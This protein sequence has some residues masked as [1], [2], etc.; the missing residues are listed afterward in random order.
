MT[1]QAKTPATIVDDA[2]VG[3][4]AWTNPANAG[5]SDDVYATAATTTGLTTHYLNAQNCGF[6]IPADARI[7]GIAVAVERKSSGVNHIDFRARI[8]KGGAISAAYTL[9]QAQ[10]WPSTDGVAIYGGP[11][12]LWAL[13]WTPADING[14]GFG[15]ALAVRQSGGAGQTASVDA[16]TITVYYT[17]PGDTQVTVVK[18]REPRPPH[19]ALLTLLVPAVRYG[20]KLRRQQTA[21]FL[22]SRSDPNLTD[23]RD[24][25]L[26]EEPAMVTIERPDGYLPWVGFVSGF[27]ASQAD[28]HVTFL[29]ADHAWR[30]SEART[31][32]SQMYATASGRI[33]KDILR[34]ME[35]RAEPALYLKYAT[36]PDGPPANYEVRMNTGLDL[37]EALAKQADSEWGFAYNVT[38]RQVETHLTWQSRQGIDR[39]DEEVWQEQKHFTKAAYS[40]RYA[41]GIRSA[42]AVGGGAASFGARPA[43]AVSKRGSAADVDKAYPR[44]VAGYGL[45]GT[46]LAFTQQVTDAAA[47]R[48]QAQQMHE[49]PENAVEQI[50]LTVL[51]S[52]IDMARF[53]LGDIRTVR[54]ATTALG[55]AIERTV[56]IIGIEMHPDTREHDVEVV[57]L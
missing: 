2:G 28:P 22:L 45:G 37:L 18:F 24:L 25:M 7:D 50:S 30:L 39:R 35:D 16:I 23:F 34:D 53:G 14:G 27:D 55:D 44:A 10:V 47:L 15:F 11:A 13:A 51:E 46:R 31:R 20:F 38:D 19:G 8:I 21:S 49:A 12:D 3:T 1:S 9:G 5:V 33:I 54:L 48:T 57:V 36:V 4:I 6:S 17:R 40:L 43:V 29:L 52:A 42:V 26:P 41:N 32:K 56:R